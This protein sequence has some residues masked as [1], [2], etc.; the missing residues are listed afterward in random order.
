MVRVQREIS[1]AQR[2][3]TVFPLSGAHNLEADWKPSG[4]EATRNRKRWEPSDA[5]R[6]GREDYVVKVVN[7]SAADMSGEWAVQPKRRYTYSW[8]HDKIVMLEQISHAMPIR[9]A[10]A[11]SLRYSTQVHILC[12]LHLIC[13]LGSHQIPMCI[14]TIR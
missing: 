14:V 6:I 11:F 10:L 4:G 13:D 5:E 2:E 7:R 9:C 8:A 12:R 3:Y 1:G